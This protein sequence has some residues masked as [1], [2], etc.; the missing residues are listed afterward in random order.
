M[1]EARQAER[2]AQEALA[3]AEVRSAP[4]DC[5]L[6]GRDAAGSRYV[7]KLERRSLGDP[8]GVVIGRNP[9]DTEFVVA[10]EA[11]SREH[12]R[13]YVKGDTLYVEDLQS[14]NGTTVNGQPVTDGNP[15][16]VPDGAALQLGPVEFRVSLKG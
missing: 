9:R 2:H 10:H 16:P 15:L 6:E 14:S 5:V 1:A 3:E 12:A 4:F 7:L 11:V 8:E 13:M